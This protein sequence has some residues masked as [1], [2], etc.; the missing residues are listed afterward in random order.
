M[1]T[2]GLMAD[3]AQVSA[4]ESSVRKPTVCFVSPAHWDRMRGGSEY[5]AKL[6]IDGL[7]EQRQVSAVY[8]ANWTPD[9]SEAYDY[10]IARISTPSWLRK[11]GAFLDA[12]SLYKHLKR[13]RPDVIFQVVGCGH[14]GI[15]AYYARNHGARMIWRVASDR[16][17]SPVAI[18]WW[19]KPHAYIERK[20]LDY[21]IRNATV[22][23]AQTR[24]QQ[25]LLAE[26]FDRSD[27]LLIRNFHPEPDEPVEKNPGPVKVLWVGNLKRLKNPAAFIRLAEELEKISDAQF[28]VIGG[29]SDD[30]EWVE[31][32]KREMASQ[33]NISYL[34]SVS[35]E[36]VNSLLAEA[37]LLV[38]TSDFEGFPNTF[39]QAWMR[40]VPVV[41]LNVDPDRLLSEK[42]LG[43]VCGT[44]ARLHEE[45]RRLID[46]AKLREEL[47]TKCRDYALENHSN[48]NMLTL[49]NLICADSE[50][51]AR[52]A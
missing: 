48:K 17:V 6:L 32:I 28:I 43:R 3:A 18:P 29:E 45:S 26:Y 39:I 51:E 22:V 38:N 35:Q 36:R 9:D 50:G 27:S 1:S 8:V 34:G 42:G 2:P 10:S 31:G 12:L 24:D 16:N 15:S 5:Q 33:P 23:V 37:H 4:R 20:F 11:Y 44:E 40:Q 47:G 52:Q 49:I 7:V 19:K 41:S 25:Q 14:T 21:G 46:D 30:P 13:I